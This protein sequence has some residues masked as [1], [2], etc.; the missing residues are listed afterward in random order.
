MGS[1]RKKGLDFP[2]NSSLLL[3]TNQSPDFELSLVIPSL[4]Y[5]EG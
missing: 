4:S 5:E 2:F 3:E 1:K